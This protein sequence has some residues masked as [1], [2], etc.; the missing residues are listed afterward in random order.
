MSFLMSGGCRSWRALTVNASSLRA[1]PCSRFSLA[2]SGGR[3]PFA[4][5][6]S[7]S[8]SGRFAIRA[9][10]RESA[11]PAPR[12][13]P[14][15]RYCRALSY[16]SWGSA[17]TGGAPSTQ[18]TPRR[19]APAKAAVLRTIIPGL[20]FGGDED[21]APSRAIEAQTGRSGRTVP[22][23]ADVLHRVLTGVRNNGNRPVGR[24]GRPGPRGDLPDG[25]KVVGHDIE[26]PVVH[27]ELDGRL[28]SRAGQD[29]FHLQ[30]GG[31]IDPADQR[32][33]LREHHR[34]VRGERERYPEGM[35]LEG[36]GLLDGLGRTGGAGRRQKE[37]QRYLGHASP[38]THGSNPHAPHRQSGTH[39][40]PRHHASP[41]RRPGGVA[42]R[43]RTNPI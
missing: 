37:K 34:T 16:I 27:H 20:S 12:S 31:Q 10:S 35:L 28:R 8:H 3:S 41:G 26:P 9:R 7:G 30:D 2:W 4:N 39:A 33:K 11:E 15:A 24:Q 14:S 38:A 36:Q 21:R 6:P 13:S 43:R 17:S 18:V 23:E 22:G 29:A 32:R 42:R 19:S 1:T 5:T 25:A 40:N